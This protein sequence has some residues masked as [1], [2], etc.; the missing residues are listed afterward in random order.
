MKLLITFFMI[1]FSSYARIGETFSECEKRYGKHVDM[2][3]AVNE[4][5]CL[6]RFKGVSILIT[7][8]KI[9]RVTQAVCIAYH[10]RNKTSGFSVQMIRNFLNGNSQG[11]GWNKVDYVEKAVRAKNDLDRREYL[12]K[13]MKLD[14][15]V[16]KD[17]E[18]VAIN[19]KNEAAFIVW[20][21]AH[22]KGVE[23]KESGF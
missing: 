13:S 20:L 6:Y 2:N 12:E 16:R 8:K 9:N 23:A 3:K 15:W 5:Q 11:K 17:S 22:Y 4:V 10:K 21:P 7:F 19:S 1:C 18:V 14:V